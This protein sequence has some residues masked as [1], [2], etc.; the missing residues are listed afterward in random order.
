VAG[1]RR[2]Y[3]M[4]DVAIEQRRGKRSPVAT[5]GPACNLIGGQVGLDVVHHLT[6]LAAPSTQG[7][8][9][10]YDL[11]TMEVEREP[12]VPELSCPV[13]DHLPTTVPRGE[14]ETKA[15]RK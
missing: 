2:D 1:Y 8:G 13:C 12:V 5:I 6:G 14:G 7:V 10:I 11:R 3:P 4:F 9:H 15:G